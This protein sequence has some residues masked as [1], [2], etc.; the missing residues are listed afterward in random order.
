MENRF[1][2]KDFFLMVMLAAVIVLLIAAMKQYDRQWAILHDLQNNAQDQTRELAQIRRAVQSSAESMDR[3]AAGGFSPRPG[4]ASSPS[5]A[6]ASNLPDLFADLKKAKADP[7]FAMGDWFVDNFGTSVNRLTPLVSTDVYASVV[8]NRVQETLL[9]RDVHTLDY[10]PVL[11]TGWQISDD[12]LTITFQLRT[13]VTFSDGQPFSADDVVFTYDW[14]MNPKVD[15]PRDRAYLEKIASVTKN[16]DYEVTFKF[17]EPYYEALALAGGL[18]VMPRHF[19]TR[20]TEEQFNQAPGLLLGTG[21]YKLRD[22]ERWRPGDQIELIR[23]ERYWG[24]PDPFDRLIYLQVQEEAAE[25]TMYRNGELDRF[26]VNQ[27]EQYV[28]LLK[29]PS[30]TERSTNWEYESVLSGYSYIAWNEKLGGKPTRFTDKRVRQ[31]MTYLTDRQRICQE[32]YLGYAS[33]CVG[34]FARL[35]P[36][37]DPSVEAYPYDPAKAKEL[38][39]AAGFEDR[40][41]DGVIEGAD[42]EPFR[43]KFT[44]FAGNELSKRMMLFLKDGYA[45]AG[46]VMDPDPVD[47]PILQ[48]KTKTRNFEAVTLG[49]ATSIESDIFQMFHSSQIK[50]GGDNDMSYV[51]P[52]L[53][54]VLEQARSTVD[55]KKRM[56]LWHRAHRI[57]AEDQPYTFMITRRATVF[58]DK[59][60]K[61]IQ[62]SKMGLNYTDRFVMPRPW[63]VP[64]ALQRYAD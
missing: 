12:G 34:P 47:W 51:N 60:I 30:I 53:D 43:F 13:G 54:K 7:A 24:E 21:P 35:S 16:G 25:N 56:E 59:R 27:P 57:I 1:G 22:P 61:N 39:K 55:D 18:N 9:T 32:I 62:K 10:V 20:F 33:P 14:I 50:D 26:A 37:N 49:W 3:L 36:Q 17:K 28:R 8:Q 6:P 23:N 58:I 11:A 29:D 31:A 46:I 40:N 19:Y 41:N 45:K 5:T 38:L 48:Q 4:A 52:E 2:V 64:K 44:Y 15:A 63:F 42:G